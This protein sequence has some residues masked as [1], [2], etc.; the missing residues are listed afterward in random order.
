MLAALLTL[1]R[2]LF[3]YNDDPSLI[4]VLAY[5]G[6]YLGVGLGLWRGTRPVSEMAGT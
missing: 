2:S 4:E 1:L 3:G 5:L 6:Y